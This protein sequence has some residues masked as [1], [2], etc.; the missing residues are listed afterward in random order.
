[1]LGNEKQ[2]S[3]KKALG[4]ILTKLLKPCQ[5]RENKT[6]SLSTKI[7]F[8]TDE[9]LKRDPIKIPMLTLE[10]NKQSQISLS[11]ALILKP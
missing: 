6:L 3:G 11:Y 5:I 4:I 1:M 2:H 10:T 7:S 9:L 8:Q